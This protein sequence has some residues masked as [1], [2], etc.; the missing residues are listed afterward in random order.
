[1]SKFEIGSA[2]MT[3]AEDT[4][5]V[6][7]YDKGWYSVAIDG[8]ESGSPTKF[9]A[10][11]LTAISD[12]EDEDVGVRIRANLENYENVVSAS[13]S[14]SYDNGDEVAQQL[15]GKGLDF[16][17]DFVAKQMFENEKTAKT[18]RDLSVADFEAQLREKYHRLNKGHQRMCL[19]NRARGLARALGDTS[20]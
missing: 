8:D 5:E 14:K 10:K 13:G 9:R 11:Q 20:E 6:V 3:D 16:C 17:Y 19:G 2:V 18:P 7:S 12:G 1:M 15:R 4:G